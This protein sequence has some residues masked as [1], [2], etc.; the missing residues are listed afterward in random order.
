MQFSVLLIMGPTEGDTTDGDDCGASLNKEEPTLRDVTDPDRTVLERNPLHIPGSSLVGRF[1]RFQLTQLLGEGG[2]GVVYA[3]EDHAAQRV[4]ALKILHGSLDSSAARDA[5]LRE[6]RIA[7]SIRHPRSVFVFSAEEVEGRPVISMEL[8]LGGTLA[9]RLRQS[10]PIPPKEV[11]GILLDLIDGLEAASEAGI[12]HRDIKPSNCFVEADG[13]VKIG[14]FGISQ[15]SAVSGFLAA[16]GRY[17]CTPG[18]ASPEQL[19]GEPVDIRS[20]IYSLGTTAFCLVI[21]R[22]PFNGHTLEQLRTAVETEPACW[23]EDGPSGVPARLIQAI[24]R[25]LAKKPEDR[26]QSYRELRAIL[27]PDA[28][29]SVEPA[30]LRFRITAGFVDGWILYLPI[31]AVGVPFIVLAALLNPSGFLEDQSPSFVMAVGLAGIELAIRLLYFGW[32]EHR[33]GATWGKRL[34]KLKVVALN[35]QPAT[36][37]QIALRS[38]AFVGIPFGVETLVGGLVSLSSL[39]ESSPQI[40]NLAGKLSA[41]VGL[42]ILFSRRSRDGYRAGWH[43][44][45]SGTRVVRRR[46]LASTA[47]PP[48]K[49]ESPTRPLPGEG[50]ATFGPVVPSHIGPFRVTD[51][52]SMTRGAVWLAAHDD[53]LHRPVWIRLSEPDAPPVPLSRRKLNRTTRL[54]WVNGLRGSGDGWDAYEAVAGC[55]VS[56]LLPQSLP[57]GTVRFWINSLAEELAAAE[58]DGTVPESLS[59]S[60]VWVTPANVIVLLDEIPRPLKKGERDSVLHAVTDARV[61]LREF[62]E[63]LQNNGA[64]RRAA[65]HTGSEDAPWPLH[66]V[67]LVGRLKTAESWDGLRQHLRSLLAQD[68]KLRPLKRFQVLL[69]SGGIPCTLAIVLLIASRIDGGFEPIESLGAGLFLAWILPSLATAGLFGLRG[70]AFKREELMVMSNVG[71]PAT[72]P[73]LL[74]RASLAWLPGL[75]FAAA[76][77]FGPRLWPDGTHIRTL[78]SGLGC[79]VI[80]LGILSACFPRSWQDRLA[81]T[82]LVPE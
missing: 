30:L 20:D 42:G 32:F 5:F 29:F 74:M 45:W 15:A 71:R 8:L 25:C 44:V 26:F 52:P 39:G 61:F 36:R 65:G 16:P 68:V 7:S 31:M 63:I 56:D 64:Q 11:L 1:G 47:T 58:T 6:G 79:L 27:A 48:L 46:P 23:P 40:E 14:D 19:R 41:L 51:E 24:L 50:P 18:Y 67:D 17:S 43:E 69:T 60:Q 55:P 2:M 66:A 82:W 12:L 73:R 76:C 81:G 78:V 59:L 37:K 33:T 80:L 57:W 70:N 72:R 4:V 10:G 49:T 13:R 75:L 54:R 22:L 34:L 38:L 3:A 77:F 53:L 62:L 28:G 21:G 9:D 35:G